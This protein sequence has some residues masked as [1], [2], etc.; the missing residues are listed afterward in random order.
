MKKPVLERPTLQ[1]IEFGIFV[2]KLIQKA[3]KE[4][5][6]IIVKAEDSHAMKAG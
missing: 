4:N 2:N 6:P 1:H 3:I 5:R